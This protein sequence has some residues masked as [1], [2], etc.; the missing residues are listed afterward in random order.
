MKTSSS[1]VVY[2]YRLNGALLQVESI[3]TDLRLLGLV[4]LKA[5]WKL[6]RL[7]NPAQ[8]R[9][10]LTVLDQN[11]APSDFLGGLTNASRKTVDYNLSVMIHS[12]LFSSSGGENLYQQTELV[13]L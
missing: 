9:L 2:F 5:R 1:G 7:L 10:A 8:V 12:I 3:Q 4:S 6:Q 13:L 11:S